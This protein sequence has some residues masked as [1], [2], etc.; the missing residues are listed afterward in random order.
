MHVPDFRTWVDLI[1]AHSVGGNHDEV[2][3]L[4]IS[5]V[6]LPFG[7]K[8]D[9]LVLQAALK[10]CAV[11]SALNLGRAIHSLAVKLGHLSCLS[12]SKGLL[13]F[14]GKTKA[15]SDTKKLFDQM[16]R[17]DTVVWNIVLAGLSSSQ[18]HDVE[19]M[20]LV[21]SMHTHSETNPNTVTLAI[22]LPVCA[23]LERLSTGKSIHSYAI[24]S[25]WASGTLVGNALI[26][27]YAKCGLVQ[28]DA[29][30]SFS[31][32]SDKDV[33]SWNAIIAG[34]AE[35]GLHKDAYSVFRHMLI[36]PV[37]PNYSTIASM[38]PVFTTL[39]KDT[40]Y[41]LG[42]ELHAYA[43]RRVELQENIFVL[44]ALLTFYLRIGLLQ[45]AEDIFDR[46]GSRDLI[47]WNAMISGYASNNEYLK[48]IHLFCEPLAEQRIV[49][50]SVTLI[51]VLPALANLHNLRML[52]QVHG[53]IFQH[54]TFSGDT[55]VSNALISSYAKCKD[56]D[57][58]YRTFNLMPQ[59]DLIS[60]NSM[61]DA[62]AGNGCELR[63]VDLLHQMLEEGF[64]PDS[65]TFLTLVQ[66]YASVSRL[67]KVKEAHGYILRAD[68]S[69]TSTKPTLAN[70][71]LDAYAKSGS[72]DYARRIFAI[73]LGK[74][75][76]SRCEGDVAHG[77]L[78]CMSQTDL[79]TCNFMIRAY[80]ENDCHEEAFAL[81]S[82]L[83][84]Q[85]A[86]LDA[87]TFMS[88]LSLC[89]KVA[90]I[91]LLRQC[92]GFVVRT[93]MEDT[94]MKG[95]LIDAYS[96]CGNP[97]LADKLFWS[98]A[99]KDLVMFTALISGYAVH[100][101]GMQALEIFKH[102]IELGV[103]PD[104]VALTAILSACSH[105]GLVDEGLRIFYSIEKAYGMKP[106]LEQY[107]CILDLLARQGEVKD[108][109]S[110]LIQM[111]VK[112]NAK[113]WGILLSA[114]RTY[115]EVELGQIVADHLLNTKGND[116]GSYVT[117]SNIHA[118]DSKWEGVRAIRELIKI[119]NLKK[120]AGCSWIE[121]DRMKSTFKSGD[122][123]HPEM[124][125]IYSTLI[126]LSK[127]VKEPCNFGHMK[128]LKLLT[129]SSCNLRDL[130]RI[131]S[132][133]LYLQRGY[134]RH[135][136]HFLKQLS[137]N[138]SA[139]PQWLPLVGQVSYVCVILRGDSKEKP[140]LMS[141]HV[142]DK[143]ENESL[144]R[145]EGKGMDRRGKG[146]EEKMKSGD[147]SAFDP[148]FWSCVLATES[149]T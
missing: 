63:L 109:Y 76:S 124:S 127:E 18:V 49:W 50:D 77:I 130:L 94:Q 118:A 149:K 99:H 40:A 148:L 71:L 28:D 64:A 41:R 133:K 32:I 46:M 11:L 125:A 53:Y 84:V 112:A 145:E 31:E 110:L 121:V 9:Q 30:A 137:S 146:L 16:P 59:R 129:D 12:V 8:P 43:L 39:N 34:F 68:L 142:T 55:A 116:I 35:K 97:S 38:L 104:H 81:F 56:L 80:V 134:I 57:S 4:F 95:T 70:A 72:I 89:A 60:W 117:M 140:Q 90:S 105:G 19:V 52:K 139:S 1:R 131:F 69:R 119:R 75:I 3:S 106:T 120:L 65:I 147:E 21:Y 73:L 96:K 141:N 102:M 10:S 136:Y 135:W 45:E 61:L 87:A 103:K 138:G 144:P 123:S 37:A 2:L 20:K 132:K 36:G 85:C 128:F 6:R 14:Y 88:L 27:M 111:P 91:Q 26:S 44:N 79:T 66:F 93:C 42:R 114:C 15:F 115:H 5:K 126:V 78:Q 25:G 74:Q 13:N 24:K 54:P 17:S 51:T 67:C 48:V 83:P 100:G 122:F 82:E 92:H 7:L 86:K 101:M 58:S 33:V 108:A 107:G 29:Y 98:S 62:L 113:I 143:D 23:R 47:S 22:I